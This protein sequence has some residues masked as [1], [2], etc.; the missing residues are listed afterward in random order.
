M[1]LSH[2]SLSRFVDGNLIVGNG[3]HVVLHTATFD[4]YLYLYGVNSRTY[5][6]VISIQIENAPYVEDLSFNVI[7]DSFDQLILD[8][9]PMSAGTTIRFSADSNIAVYGHVL[10]DI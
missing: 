3:E 1:P 8:G 7:P 6:I 10:R 5:E 4:E 2:A 9:L